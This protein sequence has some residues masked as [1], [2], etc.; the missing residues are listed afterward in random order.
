MKKTSAVSAAKAALAVRAG[1][2]VLE[3]LPIE[4]K[5]LKLAAALLDKTNLKRLGF[6]AVSG[7]AALSLGGTVL[8]TR[9]TRAAVRKELKRQLTPV[10]KKLEELEKQNEELRRQNE[11]LRHALRRKD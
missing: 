2:A 7:A 11:E 8:Q 4:E 9:L 6:V 3:K 5:K 10:N 1:K